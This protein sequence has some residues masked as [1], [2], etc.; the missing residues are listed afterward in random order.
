MGACIKDTHEVFGGKTGAGTASNMWR[1]SMIGSMVTLFLLGEIGLL[2]T[3]NPV[4]STSASV[5]TA[6]RTCVDCSDPSGE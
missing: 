6:L 2:V 5:F 4:I 1:P 3:K